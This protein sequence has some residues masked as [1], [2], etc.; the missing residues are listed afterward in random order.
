MV[1]LNSLWGMDWDMQWLRW[2]WSCGIV[3]MQPLKEEHARS[4]MRRTAAPVIDDVIGIIKAT[5][6]VVRIINL[7]HLFSC[8]DSKHCDITCNGAARR[9]ES[10]AS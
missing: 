5:R 7:I 8:T 9:R 10:M 4:M 3:D 2:A 1:S 6:S